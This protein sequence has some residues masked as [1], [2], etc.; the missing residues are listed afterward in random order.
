[1]AP[2]LGKPS[3]KASSGLPPEDEE[4]KDFAATTTTNRLASSGP[5]RTPGPLALGDEVR[6][7]P[8]RRPFPPEQGLQCSCR[9]TR[10]GVQAFD[11]RLALGGTVTRVDLP[12][13]P[14]DLSDQV[15]WLIWQT[16]PENV[17][18]YIAH[19]LE[20]QV[21]IDELDE[22][23]T[24]MLYRTGGPLSQEEAERIDKEAGWA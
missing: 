5:Q 4:G 2:A 11:K 20:K 7:S 16:A 10:L 24:E 14:P 13:Q 22:M 23:S 17:P 19:A 9:T 15:G 1:M 3:G 12:A 8:A 18:A 6:P 21:K